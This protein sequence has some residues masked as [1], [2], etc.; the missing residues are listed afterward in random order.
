L[1]IRHNPFAPINAIAIK[2]VMVEVGKRVI[3]GLRNSQV[4]IDTLDYVK[5][6][7]SSGNKGQ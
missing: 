3:M 1:G 6:Q 2:K 5:S 7:N 4:K